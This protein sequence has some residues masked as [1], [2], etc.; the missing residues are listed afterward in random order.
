MAKRKTFQTPAQPLKHKDQ[1]KAMIADN[2]QV[3]Q[4]KPIRGTFTKYNFKLIPGLPL[5]RLDTLE[6]VEL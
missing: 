2:K 4:P 3:Q 1:W 6:T 5:Y